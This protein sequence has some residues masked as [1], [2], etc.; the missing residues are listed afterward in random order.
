MAKK[1]QKNKSQKKTP[2]QK[3]DM[4]NTNVFIKGMNKDT[5]SSYFDKQ[6]WYHARNLI[7]NSID[8]DLGVVGNEPANLR[9]A[10]IPYTVIGGIHLYGDK[11]VIYSTND[12]LSE[13]GLFDDSKC[14]YTM[15]VNDPCLNFNKDNLIISAALSLIHI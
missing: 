7:N 9:C 3:T 13:I 12:T 6:S 4:I 15:L 5:D 11:W 8:G 14:E 2:A 10:E 1:Q